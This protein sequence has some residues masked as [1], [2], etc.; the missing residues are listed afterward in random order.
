MSTEVDAGHLSDLPA[1]HPEGRVKDE[2][3]AKPDPE[4]YY[5]S[6]VSRFPNIRG[7]GLI[8]RLIRSYRTGGRLL[9]IGCGRGRLLDLLQ[10]T[11]DVTGLE[12]SAHA[13]A[14]AAA[15]V[16]PDRIL[17]HD[18]ESSPPAGKYDIVVAL[19]VMEHIPTPG[20]A[21]TNIRQVMGDDGLLLFSVPNNTFGFG[22]IATMWMGFWDRTHCSALPRTAWR[23]LIAAS[24]LRLVREYHPT[25]F[26]CARGPA[27]R[28]IA[29]NLLFVAQKS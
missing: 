28:L 25:W 1:D 17:R 10:N 27:A 19:N 14:E 16:G 20:K 15:R 7:T 11:F 12:V 26:G 3:P 21:L 2:R 8:A 9:D 6:F 18:I 23:S 24:K 5:R 29:S 22:K 4:A 13:C